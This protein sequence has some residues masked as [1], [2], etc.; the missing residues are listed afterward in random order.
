[1]SRCRHI[2]LPSAS[3]TAILIGVLVL[4]SVDASPGCGKVSPWPRGILSG[5]TVEVPGGA[6][7]SREP[8]VRSYFVRV[9]EGYDPNHRHPLL[10]F[11]HGWGGDAKTIAENDELGTLGSQEGL[12]VVHAVGMADVSPS[13]GEAPSFTWGSWNGSGTVASPG[14][15]GPICAPSADAT[16]CYNS[17]GHCRDHCW[18]TTCADDIAFVGSLL[19][20]MESTLCIDTARVV[21]SGFSNGGIF[22]YELA[23]H[24]A[25]SRRLAAIAPVAG[26][27]HFGFNRPPA[28]PTLLF[29]LWGRDDSEV[30]G[31]QLSHSRHHG[32]HPEAATVSEDGY[33]YTPVEHVIERWTTAASQRGPRRKFSTPFDGQDGL[34]CSGSHA[35]EGELPAVVA[36]TWD[37]GHSWPGYWYPAPKK[38]G[39]FALA[40]RL[41][42]Q[43]LLPRLSDS[44][45]GQSYHMPFA[46]VNSMIS[47]AAT[48]IFL[49]VLILG[50]LCC[51]AW[52]YVKQREWLHTGEVCA[53]YSSMPRERP[54]EGACTA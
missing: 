32:K 26:L 2:M 3:L 11:F 36:C 22:L 31:F 7:P 53:S 44:R 10:L 35:R 15:D 45:R 9:P 39:E 27:P 33:Y 34:S 42:V 1:M 24:H 38:P 29:G 18:W 54:E 50:L 41:I 16:P 28:S 49:V 40:S 19:D 12:I 48:Q 30:P 52:R 51:I 47:Y 23:A 8:L 37:G 4:T 6:G 25:T 43:V 13:W 46:N 21:A 20:Q 17:C 14:P 5:G